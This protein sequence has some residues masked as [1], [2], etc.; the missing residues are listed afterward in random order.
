MVGTTAWLLW[1]PPALVALATY[2]LGRAAMTLLVDVGQVLTRRRSRVARV[3]AIRV[4][5]P[6]VA[7][8][9]KA[10]LADRVLRTPTVWLGLGGGLLLA[11]LWHHI[12]VSPWCLLLGGAA[13][14]MVASTGR[15]TNREDLQDLEMFLG[16]LRSVF[17]VGQSVFASLEAAGQDLPEGELRTAV[18]EAVRR[19][20][21]DLDADQALDS[22]RRV[23]SGHLGR[24]AVVLAQVGCADE[25]TIRAV[26]SDLE[27]QVRRTRRLRDRTAT[28]LTLSR[29]TLRVLQGA[30]LMALGTVT[31]VPM[32]QAFY[33]GRPLVLV[34]ATGMALAGSWYFAAE[35]RRMEDLV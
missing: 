28:V 15:R 17:T 1:L 24:L 25:E 32:W 11:I 30:N 6:V 31:L 33:A 22:L 9:S 7:S 2:V 13:G 10:T 35:M 12:V 19:Y 8:H 34:A 5:R 27:E 26:L 21:A 16:T 4:A 14:W 3:Q 29:L 20:R 23:G 18:M